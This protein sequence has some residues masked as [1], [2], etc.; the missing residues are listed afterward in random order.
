MRE[1]IR[2]GKF[3]DGRGLEQLPLLC[4]S[5]EAL[6][7][8]PAWDT[9]CQSLNQVEAADHNIP[10]LRHSSAAAVS[11]DTMISSFQTEYSNCMGLAAL[12]P[13]CH[14]L[15]WRDGSQAAVRLSSSV[16]VASTV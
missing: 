16:R 2:A 12:V 4:A 15:A 5:S 14:R 7:G 8:G 13:F 6:S 9:Q 11:Y 3:F 1:P 10:D